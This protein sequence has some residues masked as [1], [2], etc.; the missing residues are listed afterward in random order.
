MLPAGVLDSSIIPPADE[1]NLEHTVAPTM[2]KVLGAIICI[3][4]SRNS[5]IVCLA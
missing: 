1:I 2:A 3:L 4:R 5:S